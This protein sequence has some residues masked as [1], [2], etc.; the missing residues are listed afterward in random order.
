MKE[1]EELVARLQEFTVPYNLKLVVSQ[2][3]DK[4]RRPLV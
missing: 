1:G 4:A 3:A 2:F